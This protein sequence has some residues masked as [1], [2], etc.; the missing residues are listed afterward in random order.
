MSD[1]APAAPTVTHSDRLVFRD[2]L[3]TSLGVG[4]EALRRWIKAGKLP[5]P[6][7]AIT[8]R[9]M[10]WKLSTLQAAGIGLL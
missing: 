7:V 3:V 6:D 5:K 10:A 8:R 1:K 9:T 2:D 4:K